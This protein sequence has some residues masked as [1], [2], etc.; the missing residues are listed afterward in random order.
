MQSPSCSLSARRQR[1]LD[2]H[3]LPA[4]S[5][6]APKDMRDDEGRTYGMGADEAHA[7][8]RLQELF[9]LAGMKK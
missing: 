1:Y 2:D 6:D 5:C 4:I 8:R 9:G 3:R 7:S